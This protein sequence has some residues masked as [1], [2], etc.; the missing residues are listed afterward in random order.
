MEENGVT[1][2]GR[3]STLPVGALLPSTSEKSHY[4]E[5]APAETHS[6]TQ[7]AQPCCRED[8]E[9]LKTLLIQITNSKDIWT[10]P[11]ATQQRDCVNLQQRGRANEAH[12][13]VVDQKT[14]VGPEG[15]EVVFRNESS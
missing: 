7:S 4:S 5:M 8:W 10:I 3:E 11:T 1:L 6:P 15:R 14:S 9:A 2:A 13:T 12:S